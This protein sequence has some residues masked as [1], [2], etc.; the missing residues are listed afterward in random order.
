M[1]AL[2]KKRPR[3]KIYLWLGWTAAVTGSVFLLIAIGVATYGAFFLMHSSTAQGTVIAN[4]ETQIPADPRN[5]TQAQT[6]YCARFRYMSAGGVTH[7]VT[8]AT[9]SNP[10]SFKI[11][12]QVRVNYPNWD[13]GSGQ[14]DAFG[15]RWGFAI[16]FGLAAVVLTPIGFALLRR[17]R[18]Q[19][20]SLDP[21]GFW[22]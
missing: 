5:G 19:G 18:L 16:G 10:P 6:N 4:V 14:I 20:H 3:W 15:D 22:D 21:I 7:V 17:L 12:E 1:L 13:Y 9:C 2:W 8:E 11:G